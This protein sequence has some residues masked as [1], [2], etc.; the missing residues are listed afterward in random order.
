MQE[1]IA[2]LNF[3]LQATCKLAD[4]FDWIMLPVALRRFSKNISGGVV[5]WHI[6]NNHCIW[7]VSLKDALVLESENIH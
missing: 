3:H 4:K 6:S 5:Q 1:S 2:V 7:L